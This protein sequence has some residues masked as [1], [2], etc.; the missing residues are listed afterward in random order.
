[1]KKYYRISPR[2][3]ANE[4]SIISAETHDEIEYCESLVAKYNNDPNAWGKRIT[5]KEAERYTA[6]N[7][8]SYRDGSA[9]S[10]NPAGATEITTV[11]DYMRQH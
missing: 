1:M 5:R 3:F 7:R 11:A 10:N 8:K 2:G 6:A 4:D 9:N